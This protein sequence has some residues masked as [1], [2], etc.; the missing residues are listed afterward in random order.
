M[1]NSTI[2]SHTITTLSDYMILGKPIQLNTVRNK[3]KF[4]EEKVI[5]CIDYVPIYIDLHYSDRENSLT[6]LK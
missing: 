2:S 5:K 1:F 3:I 6:I 4:F